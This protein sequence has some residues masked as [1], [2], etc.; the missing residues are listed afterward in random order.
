MIKL[1]DIL[2]ELDKNYYIP[3]NNIQAP[4]VVTAVKNPK[5][6]YIFNKKIKL[7]DT[8]SIN[9]SKKIHEINIKLRN[10]NIPPIVLNKDESESTII[11][12]KEPIFDGYEFI[13][14]LKEDVLGNTVRLSPYA[15]VKSLPY[16]LINGSAMCDVCK[17]NRNRHSI[18]LL[19]KIDSGIFTKVGSGCLKKFLPKR[20]IDSLILYVHILGKLNNILKEIQNPIPTVPV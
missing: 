13:G 14:N 11:D 9:L 4:H 7:D 15:T 16:A 5:L 6:S 17:L 10:S 20:T 8:Q 2:L 12:W 1:R 19:R 3:E 18:F